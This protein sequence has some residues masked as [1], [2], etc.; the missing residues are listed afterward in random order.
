M[1]NLR[2]TAAGEQR[3]EGPGTGSHGMEVKGDSARSC[4]RRW[5]FF[6][7]QEYSRISANGGGGWRC[8]CLFIV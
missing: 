8:C 5:K 7:N 1:S 3:C 4:S 2:N 6:L